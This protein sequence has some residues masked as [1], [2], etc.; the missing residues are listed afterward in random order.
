MVRELKKYV[1]N[2]GENQ[3]MCIVSSQVYFKFHQ[4]LTHLNKDLEHSTF[5]KTGVDCTHI[6][7]IIYVS[8]HKIWRLY[9]YTSDLFDHSGSSV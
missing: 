4:F 5:I 6:L 2:I 1:G 7:N 8:K 9:Y 3:H